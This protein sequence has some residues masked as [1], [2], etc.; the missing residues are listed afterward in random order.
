MYDD[1]RAHVQEMLDIG[2]ICKLH[3]PW[4]SAVVLVQKK[5]GSLR[6][7]I[8]FRKLNNWT[9]KD[10][11]SLPH[12]D[13]T[14]DSLQSSQ[15]F[16]S[17]N[18]KSGYWQM[19]MDEE[20]KPLT[21]FTVEPLGFYKCERMPFK[22]TNAPATFQRLMEN[23]LGDLNLH[24]CIIYLDDIAIFSK[25]LVSHLEGLGAV[26]WKLEKAGL[27]LKP[28]KCELF[29]WQI[30]LPRT[31]DF[32]PRSNHWWRQ[33]WSYQEMANTHKCH[34]GLKF[35]GIHGILLSVYT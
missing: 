21:A 22:L 5:D 19:K 15:W 34:W 13:E 1:V 28:S 4:A 8:N 10:T 3:S 9:V 6:F 16:S 33:N 11:Y 27:K 7:C 23:C 35:L 24:W 2:A 20:S 32:C 30:C 25:D 17:L 14:L 31:C 12:I 18:L 26:F 29:Q